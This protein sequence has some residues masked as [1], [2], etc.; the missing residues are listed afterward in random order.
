MNAKRIF[1]PAGLAVIAAASLALS[2]EACGNSGDGR[3][4]NWQSNNNWTNG[5]AGWNAQMRRQHQAAKLA[6]K[7]ERDNQRQVAL[8][9]Y[10][11]QNLQYPNYLTAQSA[12][13]QNYLAPS[14]L[15]TYPS[16]VSYDPYTGSYFN[17]QTAYPLN[18]PA[19]L[20]SSGALSSVANSLLQNLVNRY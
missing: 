10:Y 18:T 8:Q 3:H 15:A 12:L 17:T 19:Y 11:N 20:G 4:G 13:P 5:N 16:Q 9:Q 1:A 2:A 7:I 14:T 6:R